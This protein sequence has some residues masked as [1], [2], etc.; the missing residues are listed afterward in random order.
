VRNKRGTRP[1][2]VRLIMAVA[3]VGLFFVGYQWGNQFQRG[4]QEPLKVGGILLRP[5]LALPD[6]T[7]SGPRGELSE[8]E[9][10]GRWSLLAFGAPSSAS[11][12]RA[13]SRLIEV[14]TRSAD[15]RELQSSLQ[16]LLV[17]ADDAP[18]LARDFERLSPNLRVVN[19]SIA[20]LTELRAAI[21]AGDEPLAE[22]DASPPLYLIGPQA[23][24][25]AL[26]TGTQPAQSVAS[27]LKTLAERPEALPKPL[28]S[29]DE[30][31]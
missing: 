12:H 18:A 1:L 15:D 30:Q 4:S 7:L 23:A 3:A 31:H 9:L 28:P 2:A 17:S 26:F 13:V 21:G 29:D 11:G 20:Q 19:T 16:L 8:Q 14:W 25:V 27:D 6:I 10:R 5:P 24:L 22:I